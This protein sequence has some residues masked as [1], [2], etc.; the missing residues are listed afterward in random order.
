MPN[1]SLAANVRL[2]RNFDQEFER[3]LSKQTAQ[4][5]IP[6]HLT[7]S[8][9][10]YGYMLLAEVPG[11]D[12]SAAIRVEMQRQPAR[13]LQADTQRE[14]LSRLG[15]TVYMAESVIIDDEVSKCFIPSSQLSAWRREITALLDKKILDKV[16]YRTGSQSF[17]QLSPQSKSLQPHSD[18]Q[19]CFPYLYNVANRNAMAFYKQQG[20]HI[21]QL[22]YELSGPQNGSLLMQCKHC[23]R[24]AMGYCVK[25]GGKKPFWKEPLL[26]ALSDGRKFRLEFHCSLCQMYIYAQN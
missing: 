3:K 5:R 7:L 2:Y 12:L 13:T 26:L 9:T 22:A 17:S 11:E 4:R 20:V 23:V 1:G 18:I 10:D 19:K 6:L 24:Y 16:K 21:T 15:Q 14:Q 25:N 8:A